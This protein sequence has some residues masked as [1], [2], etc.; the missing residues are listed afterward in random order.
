M[1]EEKKRYLTTNIN[2]ITIT[3]ECDAVW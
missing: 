1:I 2:S 3:F